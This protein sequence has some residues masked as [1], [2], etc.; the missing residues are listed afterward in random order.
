M[1]AATANLAPGLDLG[2][3]TRPQPAP[4]PNGHRPV[5]ETVLADLQS[6]HAA[7]P[8]AALAALGDVPADLAADMAARDA[9]GRARYGT[10][11][12]PFN[13]RDSFA[14][15]YQELLDAIVYARQAL[16]DAGLPEDMHEVIEHEVYRTLLALAAL[17]RA[18]LSG[19]ARGEWP[20]AD[21]EAA[22]TAAAAL[23]AAVAGGAGLPQANS[24]RSA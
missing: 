11:L 1:T 23:A 18:M 2:P 15:C 3:A 9:L 5:W 10:P 14:D 20:A 17:V 6:F 21:R 4:T 12:Q 22:A 19:R 13:G 8:A 7:A 16:I 24:G